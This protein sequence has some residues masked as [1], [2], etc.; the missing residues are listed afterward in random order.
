MNQH[1]SDLRA[2][3]TQVC[4][5]DSR[6][7]KKMMNDYGLGDVLRDASAKDLG[8]RDFACQTIINCC[9]TDG[10]WNNCTTMFLVVMQFMNETCGDPGDVA[11]H[12]LASILQGKPTLS[13][14]E[15]WMES[16][17]P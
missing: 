11:Y 15:R 14:V 3:L 2:I 9:C 16:N 1:V 7:F 5:S 6:L 8:P 13:A 10:K 12:D 4:S 17:F